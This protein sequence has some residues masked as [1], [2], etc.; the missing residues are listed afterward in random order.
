MVV[1]PRLLATARLPTVHL[2][3]P[4]QVALEFGSFVSK[5]H[6]SKAWMFFSFLRHFLI[7]LS[8]SFNKCSISEENNGYNWKSCHWIYP[9]SA[10]E[11]YSQN[12]EK[13]V[14]K[15]LNNKAN[16]KKDMDG[17]LEVLKAVKPNSK[18]KYSRTSHKRSQKCQDLTA[19]QLASL[20]NR[21]LEM[22]WKISSNSLVKWLPLFFL[23]SCSP[24]SARDCKIIS[25]R[26]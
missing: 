8:C 9:N 7:L 16:T 13:K 19:W 2:S 15:G 14:K 26:L 1:A 24:V 20:W 3:K 11:K 17:Q 4:C 25:A 10:T 22:A 18:I 5:R 21:D 12:R 6:N 23:V